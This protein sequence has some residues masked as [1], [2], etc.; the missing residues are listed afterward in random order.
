MDRFKDMWLIVGVNREAVNLTGLR[1]FAKTDDDA[2]EL[3]FCDG[4]YVR[5]ENIDT[6]ASMRTLMN[7]VS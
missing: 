1:K 5:L 6:D 2:I 7:V 3:I 4:C